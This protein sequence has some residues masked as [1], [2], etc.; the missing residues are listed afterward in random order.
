MQQGDV[1]KMR[2]KYKKLEQQFN[3]R[4]VLNDIKAKMS[5]FIR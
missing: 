1:T 2:E 3:N 4:L 5:I